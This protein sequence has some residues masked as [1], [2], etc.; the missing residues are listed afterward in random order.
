MHWVDDA[1]VVQVNYYRASGGTELVRVLCEC[2]PYFNL[3]QNLE[4]K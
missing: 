1:G 2:F 4:C 3:F